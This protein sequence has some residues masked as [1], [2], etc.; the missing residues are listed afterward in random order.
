LGHLLANGDLAGILLFGSF[1]AFA[2]YD[3]ISV[4]RRAALGPL[5]G[6]E[7][8][9]PINDVVVVILGLALFAWLLLGGHQWLI[10]VSPL[11]ELG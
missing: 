1:L 9:S 8:A 7:P 5:G 3:R 6:K 4:K 2:V 10:G 11:P